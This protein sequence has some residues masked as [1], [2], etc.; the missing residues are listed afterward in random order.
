MKAQVHPL[1]KTTLSHSLLNKVY[2]VKRCKPVHIHN[3][4]LLLSCATGEPNQ[5]VNQKALIQLI[6]LRSQKFLQSRLNN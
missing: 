1:K 6:A 3:T 4:L 2:T 5:N